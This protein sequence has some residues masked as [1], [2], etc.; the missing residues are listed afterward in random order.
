MNRFDC[1]LAI[2][3]SGFGGSVCALRAAE[4]RQRVIVL[5]RGRRMDEN[6]YAAIA[7]GLLPLVHSTHRTGLVEVPKIAGLLCLAG[8]AVGGGSHVYTAVTV[9]AP[10]EIFDRG[11][12]S[13]INAAK[14]AG[15][16]DR[17]E[18]IIDPAPVPIALPRTTTLERIG[19]AIGSKVTRLPLSI[20]WQSESAAPAARGDEL[21]TRKRIV[22]WLRGGTLA[23]KRTLDATYLAKA[24][25]AG[26]EVR[27]MH[28]ASSII[29]EGD[30]YRIEYLN[31]S[32]AG[33]IPGAIRARQVVI[34][35][36]T[37]GTI[38]LLFKCRDELR[39]LA[40]LSDLLGRR[41]F[42]NGDLGGVLVNPLDGA[43]ADDG[44]PTTA[45]IDHWDSD[46]LYVM[47]LGRLPLP[48]MLDR[49]LGWLSPAVGAGRDGHWA[50]GV[51]GFDETEHQIIRKL[52]GGFACIRH[53]RVQSV[54]S[55]RAQERLRE[56]AAA[57]GGRLVMP[58][59]WFLDRFAVTVHPLGGAAMADSP[60]QGVTDSHGEVFGCP[61]LFVADGSLLPTPIGRP[62]SMTIAALAERVAERVNQRC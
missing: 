53:E 30:G 33:T 1:D 26:A 35:A 32:D 40:G 5:E 31:R 12:P 2:I 29:S 16:F 28:E 36:G 61:G 56:L 13:D 22:S 19:A 48:P 58:P 52:N 14:L 11:W 37:L 44:P 6:A 55:D 15:Y 42:T 20:R 9:R 4:A 10:D 62:P 39:S 51:M 57:T 18:R 54:F 3:G 49:V 47:E 34:A 45:W 25:Q 17:V 7:D 27:S 23:P 38:R 60:E 41:F 8:C 21:D 59:R 46:R 43:P 50:F 24:Q